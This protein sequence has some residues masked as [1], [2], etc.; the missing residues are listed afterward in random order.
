MRTEQ[1]KPEGRGS[2]E[3]DVQTKKK[4]RSIK[5]YSI[6]PSGLKIFLTKC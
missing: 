5:A 6:I 1:Y 3:A 4:E 2:Q